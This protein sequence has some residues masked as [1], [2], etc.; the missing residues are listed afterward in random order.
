MRLVVGRAQNAVGTCCGDGGGARQ[1]HEVRAAGNVQR[2][3]GLQRDINRAVAALGDQVQSVV[4]ELAEQGHPAVERRRQADVR[5]QVCDG[6]A[7]VGR[8]FEAHRYR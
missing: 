4:E 6:D 7:A 5:R 2:V 8:D 3:I 1:G